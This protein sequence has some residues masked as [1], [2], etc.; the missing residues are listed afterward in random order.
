[1]AHTG[2]MVRQEPT[3]ESVSI[4]AMTSPNHTPNSCPLP[5]SGKFTV[6]VIF[7]TSTPREITL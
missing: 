5:A 1:M 2:M 3:P 6:K 7:E 4:L